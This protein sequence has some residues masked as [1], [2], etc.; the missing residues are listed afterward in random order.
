MAKS[1]DHGEAIEFYETLDKDEV[2]TSEE[3][4]EQSDDETDDDESNDGETDDDTEDEEEDESDDDESETD[5]DDESEDEDAEFDKKFPQLKGETLE[6]YK[7]SLEEAYRN[8]STEGQRLKGLLDKAEP[9]V[10][11]LSKIIAKHPELAEEI[12]EVATEAADTNAFPKDP[13]RVLLEQQVNESQK[14]EYEDFNQKLVDQGIDLEADPTLAG[15]L[16]S[17]LAVVRDHVWRKERRIV[18]MGEGLK[19]AWKLMDKEP[20]GES[21]TD[22]VRKAAKR[23]A[24]QRRNAGGKKVEAKGELTPAQRQVAERFGLDPKKVA[25]HVSN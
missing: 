15:E 23:V 25:R 3:E 16:N 20:L 22:K 12:G 2:E 14:K 11:A 17:A 21:K 4:D 18:G 19:R 6:E 10:D 9:A 13:T 5:D 1:T 24:G 8:T 7:D